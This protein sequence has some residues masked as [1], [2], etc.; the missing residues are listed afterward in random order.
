MKRHHDQ[1]N[2]YKGDYF[3]EDGLQVKRFSHCGKPH[4]YCPECTQT[5]RLLEKEPRV[6]HLDWQGV[7]RSEPLGL[8]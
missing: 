6:L 3:I 1:G 2:S 8:P 5:D 4:H 7:G